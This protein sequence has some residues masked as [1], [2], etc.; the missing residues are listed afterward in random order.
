MY[1]HVSC[2]N[3]MNWP[4]TFTGYDCGIWLV[5]TYNIVRST[6][7]GRLKGL[8]SIRYLGPVRYVKILE[9]LRPSLTP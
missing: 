7:M 5:H 9:F 2:E 1:N 8:S 3:I 4:A 6:L